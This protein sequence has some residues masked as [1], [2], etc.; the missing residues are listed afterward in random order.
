MTTSPYTF[1]DLISPETQATIRARL[2]A[3]LTANGQPTG[4]WAPSS[5]GGLENLRADMVSGGL[6]TLCAARVAALVRGRLLELAEDSAE[7]GY[8]LSYLGLRFYGLPKRAASSTIQNIA[9][10]ATTTAAAN[11][12][13][14]GDLWVKSPATGNRYRLTLAAGQTITLA[15]GATVNAPFQAEFPGGTYTDQAGTITQMVTAKAGVS[16]I[17][18]RPYDFAPMRVTGS[19]TGKVIAFFAIPGVAPSYNSFR[20]RIDVTGDV[21]TGA[22]S[23]S[24]DGG[25]TWVPGGPIPDGLN[26]IFA[27]TIVAFQNGLSPSFVEGMVYTLRVG[28]CFLQRGADAET[29]VAYRSRL[30]NRWPAISAI[31]LRGTIELWS[32]EASREVVR[33]ASDADPNIP[34]GILVTIASQSGPATTAAQEAVEDYILPRLVGF[35]GVPAPTSPAVVDSQ[36]PQESIQVSSAVAFEVAAAATIYVPGDQL[37]AARAGADAAWNAYL[38]VVPIGDGSAIVE[39]ERFRTILGD[40]GAIDIQGLTLNGSAADLVVP[41]GEVSTPASGWTL[42]AKLTWIPMAGASAATASVTSTS[43]GTFTSD[44][45]SIADL[46][47]PISLADVKAFLLAYLAVPENQVT[48]WESGAALRTYWELESLIIQDLMG[49]NLANVAANG[50]PDTATGDSLTMVARGWYGVDRVTATPGMQ[51]VAIACD[52][53]HGPYS[54]AQV[55]A[56][57]GV[58]TDGTTYV[59][60]AGAATLNT[61]SE[62]DVTMTAESPGAVRALVTALQASLPGVRVSASTI[63]TFGSDGDGDAAISSTI[64]A[65]FPDLGTIPSQ[66]RTITWALAAAPPPLL[67]RF[68]LDAD[69]AIPGGVLMTLAN[70]TGAV[71]GGTVTAV[72]AALD[73][74]SPITDNNTA[75]N[76]SNVSVAVTG[77]VTIKTELAAAAQAAADAAWSAYLSTAQIGAEVFLQA[78]SVAVGDAIKADP[79]SNFENPA[80]TGAGADGN[81]ALAATEV[82]VPAA[83]LTSSLTWVLT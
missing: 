73:L 15:P 9:L 22:F 47:P 27:G 80:I 5:I 4:S 11:T 74:L 68:R 17:N 13:S 37:A 30:S 51:T 43:I 78:L 52:S 49:S 76:S 58:A 31:P 42:A 75:Q 3:D 38:G 12:F 53:A 63:A 7:T 71:A 70:A 77:T 35:K 36:S 24:L 82:P 33:V 81:L 41:V 32:M 23:Y 60:T 79:M 48:D 29:D 39:L 57:V 20:I 26:I 54:T 44:P 46:L 10:T 6:A 40:L 2:I 8:F 69:P 19:G 65:R 21:G 1:D 83:T 18:V 14:D 28:D 50:Y 55:A 62:V 34:G 16:C 64:A 56:L 66:D 45:Q 72:Q 61:G 59:V 25:E 67:T